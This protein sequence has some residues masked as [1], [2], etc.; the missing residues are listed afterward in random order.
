MMAGLYKQDIT[1]SSLVIRVVAGNQT[2]DTAILK[3]DNDTI[4][5]SGSNVP[6]SHNLLIFLPP[7]TLV[8][9]NRC[10][11]M[12]IIKSLKDGA[13]FPEDK[14]HY[15]WITSIMILSLILW[16][17][18]R[19]SAKSNFSEFKKFIFLRGINESA[20]RD[21]GSLFYWQST[22]LN[23]VSFLLI[24]LFAYC[25][26]AF[27]DI[28]PEN[29]HPFLFLLL[30]LGLVIFCITSRH[31]ICIVTGNISGEPEM[32]N[33]YLMTIYNSYRFGAVILFFLLVLLLYTTLLA[34]QV[35]FTGGIIVF[36]VFYLYRILRLLLIFM[37]RNVSILYLI[38]YLCA[39]EILPVLI[40]LKYFTGHV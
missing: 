39:L 38:L 33:E 15:D 36:T 26:A 14:L 3:P 4:G 21:I 12:G 10:H 27:N 8:T 2:L 35:Y 28:I 24:S 9:E 29:I 18:V 40:L 22:I 16:I 31:L 5:Y 37:K 1:D 19:I 34:P 6:F 30:C 23:F 13:G 11:K 25:A 20:S 32:F 7:E 17:V